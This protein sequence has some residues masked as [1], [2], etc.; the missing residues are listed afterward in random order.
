MNHQ[1][2]N[3]S[4]LGSG[5]SVCCVPASHQHVCENKP[6]HMHMYSYI[7]CARTPNTQKNRILFNNN[8]HD[9]KI[10]FRICW[11]IPKTAEIVRINFGGNGA[12]QTKQVIPVITCEIA[13]G[14]YVYELVSG[15]NVY[16]LDLGVQIDSIKQPIK[17][18]PVASGN[19]SHCRNSALNDHFDHCSSVFKDVQLRLT[20][21]RVC[22][23]GDVVHMRQLINISASL[24][25]GVGLVISRTVSCCG[26]GWWF[27]TVWWP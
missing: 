26:I 3:H 21:R 15:V 18:N 22:V 5:V 13:L 1:W 27:G 19:M 10:R 16:D 11:I 7:V 8:F 2:H 9:D 17:S 25:F 14:Q 20:L 6:Q 12:Q 23:W 24:L 4:W